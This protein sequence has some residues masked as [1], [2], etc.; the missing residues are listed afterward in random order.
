MDKTALE[1]KGFLGDY[2]K[3]SANQT[4]SALLPIALLLS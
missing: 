2:R 1:N 3:C 4:Y